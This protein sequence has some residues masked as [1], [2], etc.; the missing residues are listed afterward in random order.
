MRRVIICTDKTKYTNNNHSNNNFNKQFT[1]YVYKLST[2]VASNHFPLSLFKW[3]VLSI[4][5]VHSLARSAQSV[6]A[7]KV[8]TYIDS[9]LSLHVWIGLFISLSRQLQ[10]S[11]IR[12]NKQ[13]NCKAMNEIGW[14][15]CNFH[16]YVKRNK[17][18]SLFIYF[19]SSPFFIVLFHR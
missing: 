10:T 19:S 7:T 5:C 9:P 15:M 12:N 4:S 1:R 3:F 2:P 14:W 13:P 11:G 17:F 16:I 18:F 8:L 6:G